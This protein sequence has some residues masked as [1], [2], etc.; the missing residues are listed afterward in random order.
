MFY[1]NELPSRKMLESFQGDY[2]HMDPE[3]T[4]AFL[5]LMKTFRL[6]E[7]KLDHYFSQY[8]SSFAKFLVLMTLER[9]ESKSVYA[10][11]ISRKI[12]T[13]KKNLSRLVNTLEKQKL[14]K[15]QKSKEDK[16]ADILMITSQGQNELYTILPGYFKIINSFF[17]PYS[18]EEAQCLNDLLGKIYTRA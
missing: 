18:N 5:S 3:K 14:L 7:L 12:G 6:V 13:S 10:A 16:R 4:G 17:E 2:P 15:K 11:E 9:E 8:D 1:L